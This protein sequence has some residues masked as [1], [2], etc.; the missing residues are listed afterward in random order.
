MGWIAFA[1]REISAANI[2]KSDG[3]AG[4]SVEKIETSITTNNLYPGGNTEGGIVMSNRKLWA[5][6][7]GSLTLG[8]LIAWGVVRLL[9][10]EQAHGEPTPAPWPTILEQDNANQAMA[11]DMAGNKTPDATAEGTDRDSRS[12]D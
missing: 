12:S 8:L 1:S 6:T 5:I 9:S 4:A 11:V 3:I 7:L 2:V 10:C